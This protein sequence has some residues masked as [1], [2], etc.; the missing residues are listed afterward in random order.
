MTAISAVSWGGVY[1][2][3]M[4]G[5]VDEHDDKPQ[6]ACRPDRLIVP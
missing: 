6:N 5:P 2:A 4:R 3:E 1:R